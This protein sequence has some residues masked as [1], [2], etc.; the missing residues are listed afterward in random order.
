MERPYI[1]IDPDSGFLTKYDYKNDKEINKK[2]SS[3]NL[4]I[5]AITE[6]RQQLL[7]EFSDRRR[8]VCSSEKLASK[9]ELAKIMSPDSYFASPIE[10][11]EVKDYLMAKYNS[12]DNPPLLIDLT[13]VF[14]RYVDEVIEF[15]IVRDY[16][17]FKDLTFKTIPPSMVLNLEIDG[18]IY[19]ID[20]NSVSSDLLPTLNVFADL[21]NLDDLIEGWRGAYKSKPILNAVLGY[22]AACMY[23]PEIIKTRKNFPL[24]GIIGTTA[25]GKTAL[26]QTLYNFWGMNYKPYN[27]PSTSPFVELAQLCQ[28]SCFPIWRDEF[29]NEGH[30]FAK[31][32]Y[33]RSLYDRTPISK[34][35]SSQ[36]LKNYTPK[37]TLLLTG[38]DIIT[39]PALRRRFVIFQLNDKYK[40]SYDEWEEVSFKAEEIFPSLFNHFVKAK[41][42]EEVYNEIMLTPLT[43][44]NSELEEKVL[45]AALGAVAGREYGIQAVKEADQFWK[46]LKLTGD[47]L[48]NRLS[49]VEEFFEFLQNFLTVRGYYSG[50][51]I[52]GNR[53]P[54]EVHKL[55]SS[56]DGKVKIYLHGLIDLA[57]RNGFKEMTSLGQAAL[58]SMV[59]DYF[60][61]ETKSIRLGDWVGKGLE[62]DQTNINIDSLNVIIANAIS[63]EKVDE[64]ARNKIEN[65][66]FTLYGR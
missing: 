49:S 23:M 41:W 33:L 53:I 50:K 35:T 51:T 4:S 39:D 21:D 28:A 52:G 45:Y 37:G 27:Y 8:F 56:N 34:G 2:L 40:L 36:Q 64:D 24:M 66:K 12:L 60:T 47:K 26:L 32:S 63:A 48:T 16:V 18:R 62:L 20:I 44:D 13:G 15:W 38:E 30:A 59:C 46:E 3:T 25:M 5:L 11:E 55:I 31:Q 10:H 58:K 19:H 54:A 65:N 14:G 57:F 22:F 1:A 17:V 7:L 43:T 61:C 42:N 6:D 29:R 9:Q